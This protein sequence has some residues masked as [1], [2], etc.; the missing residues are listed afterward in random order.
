MRRAGT[1]L[2]LLAGLLTGWLLGHTAET[3]AGV[4]RAPRTV[5]VVERVEVKVPVPGERVTVVERLP[6]VR[7]AA[8]V[9]PGVHAPLEPV[10]VEPGLGLLEFD[11]NCGD[12]I[13][14]AAIPYVDIWGDECSEE[15]EDVDEGIQHF[16][17]VPGVYDL[18]W[19]H[20]NFDQERFARVHIAAGHVTRVAASEPF[21]R[22]QCWIPPGLGAVVIRVFDLAGDPVAVDDLTLARPDLTGELEEEDLYIEE[23]GFARTV[24]LPGEYLLRVGAHRMRVF[25]EAGR[26]TE[27]A[28]RPGWQGELRFDREPEGSIDL[29]P[30]GDDDAEIDCVAMEEYRFLFLRPGR[31][32]V[33]HQ[34]GIESSWRPVGEVDIRARQE[35]TF[36]LPPLPEGEVV[37]IMHGI[38]DTGFE[39]TLKAEP[40]D[41]QPGAVPIVRQLKSKN[42]SLPVSMKLVALHPGRWRVHAAVNGFRPTERVVTVGEERVTLR[43]WLEPEQ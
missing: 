16:T 1:F 39:A 4:S 29:Q 34:L 36:E 21:T 3:V 32:R 40:L 28:V 26:T 23:W 33:R 8:K 24:L 7:S 31:Y 43:L 25:I 6:V 14:E 41:A 13:C 10:E 30:V 17:L 12:E 37:V 9:E 2:L 18:V 5:T 27:V 38:G 22:D 19:S 20:A 11:G 15:G 35:V 42:W